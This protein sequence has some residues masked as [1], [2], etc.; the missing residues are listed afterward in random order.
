VLAAR[1]A[2]SASSGANAT[3]QST[4]SSISTGSG[5][6]GSRAADHQ[7]QAPEDALVAE[8]LVIAVE[9]ASEDQALGSG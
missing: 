1:R 2:A 3:R 6:S 4:T 7:G 8:Q 5:G 9:A